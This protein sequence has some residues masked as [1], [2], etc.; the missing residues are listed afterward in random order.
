MCLCVITIGSD[1]EKS[2]NLLCMLEKS[3]QYRVFAVIPNRVILRIVFL[4]CLTR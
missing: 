2:D 1:M 4:N 3:L